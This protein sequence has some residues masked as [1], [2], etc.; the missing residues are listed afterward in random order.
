[1]ASEFDV[2]LQVCFRHTLDYAYSDEYQN[3]CRGDCI[4]AAVNYR[5]S[6]DILKS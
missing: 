6:V 4:L 3:D 1:M 2:E 5:H